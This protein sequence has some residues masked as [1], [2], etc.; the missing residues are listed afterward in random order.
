MRALY[1]QLSLI[2]HA[3][4]TQA[5]LRRLFAAVKITNAKSASVSGRNSHAQK[6]AFAGGSEDART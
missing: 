4:M 1:F 3:K 5:T 6:I 2:V